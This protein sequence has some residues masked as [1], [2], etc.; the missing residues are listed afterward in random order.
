MTDPSVFESVSKCYAGTCLDASA[1][2][3]QLGSLRLLH[4]QLANTVKG[5]QQAAAD[6]HHLQLLSGMSTA[7]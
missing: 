1:A 4:S 7:P 2:N 5:L 3:R 6:A